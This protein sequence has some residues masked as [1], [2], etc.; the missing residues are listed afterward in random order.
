MTE[1]SAIH[2][3]QFEGDAFF[4]EGG[5]V[6]VLLSH[7]YTATTVEVRRLAKIL[8]EKGYTVSGPLL[9]G[10]G[11][12]PEDMNKHTWEDW[13]QAI[14]RAYLQLMISCERIFVG[15][16]SMGALLAL[17]IASEYEDIEGI[18]A[19]APA[20]IAQTTTLD[21]IKLKIGSLFISSLPK[22]SIDR[23]DRWQGYPVHPLRGA[24]QLLKLQNEIRGRLP[25]I[26]QPIL[27]M[28]GRHDTS[29]A[30]EVPDI[31]DRE[32]GSTDKEIHWLEN[33]CHVMLLDDELDKIVDLT[34]K[35]MNRVL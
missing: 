14:E 30:P 3:P 18:L 26:K 9:P 25:R 4:W 32:I 2:N 35:F 8:H 33:S 22:D 34:L 28:Q 24:Q 19:Y 27:I 7:G 12:T 5:E 6:G 23:A 1:K 31:I 13:A 17:Y 11:T 29:V 10:H 21:L 15:G 16:E 20:L